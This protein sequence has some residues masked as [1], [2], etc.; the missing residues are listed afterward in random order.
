MFNPETDSEGFMADAGYGN[1][2]AARN[3]ITFYKHREKN[4]YKSEQEGRPVWDEKDFICI[5]CPGQDKQRVQRPVR[6]EDIQEYSEAWKAYCEKRKQPVNGTP[7]AD[8]P[9]MTQSILTLMDHGNITT[10]EQ[11]A[12][13]GDTEVQNLGPNGMVLRSRAKSFLEGSNRLAAENAELRARLEA[14]EARLGATA[15][16]ERKK[17]GRKPKIESE[18][19]EEDSVP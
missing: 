18:T 6:D 9:G 1:Q 8:L 7:I 11:L 16:V 3:T 15:E 2:N 5:I 13:I 10:I 17:P 14:L 19:E 4:N 12:S